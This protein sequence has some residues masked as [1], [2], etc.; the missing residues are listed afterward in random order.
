[1]LLPFFCSLLQCHG[2]QLVF[3]EGRFGGGLF[4]GLLEAA[5]ALPVALHY[6]ESLLRGDLRRLLL[7]GA[8]QHQN[9]FALGGRGG[10]D[11]EL[12]QGSVSAD[13][14]T[15]TAYFEK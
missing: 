9:K 3:A 1:M 12:V 14:A 8:T 6:G 10:G 7:G 2:I 15:V 5:A 11:A 13:R 4:A